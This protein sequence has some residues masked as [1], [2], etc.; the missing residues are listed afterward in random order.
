MLCEWKK[1]WCDRRKNKGS[2]FRSHVNITDL[3][4]QQHWR[5]M[6]QQAEWQPKHPGEQC[7]SKKLRECYQSQPQSSRLL[8]WQYKKCWWSMKSVGDDLQ[9]KKIE[10]YVIK[11]N[12]S[13]KTEVWWKAIKITHLQDNEK[14]II[15]IQI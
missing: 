1:N 8:R 6:F 14:P 2:K 5:W 10:Y 12:N 13:I 7:W 11:K 15:I 3:L 4:G 9:M